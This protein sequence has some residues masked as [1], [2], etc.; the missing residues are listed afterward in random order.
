MELGK[1]DLGALEQDE[2][3]DEAVRIILTSQRGSSS[4]LQRRL[5]VGYS[6]ASRLIEQMAQAG[7]VGEY[8]GSQARDVLMTLDEYE[9]LKSQ[10]A[11][12]VADGLTD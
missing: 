4:L 6:R 11:Q 2:M 10:M 3:F 8:R 5:G 1:V 7:I 12:E 9:A